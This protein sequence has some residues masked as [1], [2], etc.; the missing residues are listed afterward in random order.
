M[1]CS[2]RSG[3]KHKELTPLSLSHSIL[4]VIMISHKWVEGTELHPSYTQ[5]LGGVAS[6]AT[7]VRPHKR[8]PEQTELQH[9]WG[10]GRDKSKR[11]V[12]I[13]QMICGRFKKN[14]PVTYR[15]V[16]KTRSNWMTT[17]GSHAFKQYSI[18]TSEDLLTRDGV[19]K[20]LPV[21]PDVSRP[22][23]REASDAREGG[24][25][26]DEGSLPSYFHKSAEDGSQPQGE[27]GG[28]HK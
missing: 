27:S 23:S 13:Y 16:G 19:S 5:L 2:R 3:K 12:R 20:L 18:M 15:S 22:H 8:H 11:S 24:A 28:Q 17:K 7:D 25:R 1:D 6:K 4:L 21:T 14:R 9:R 10:G 26:Q